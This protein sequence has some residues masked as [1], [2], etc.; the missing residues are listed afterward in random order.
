MRGAAGCSDAVHLALAGFGIIA[1]M[2]LALGL[3]IWLLRTRRLV[4]VGWGPSGYTGN[5]LPVL[6]PDI[7]Q[8]KW[9]M[10]RW[11]A[12]GDC[13]WRFICFFRACLASGKR[14][15]ISNCAVNGRRIWRYASCFFSSFSGA[16]RGAVAAILA[17][18]PKSRRAARQAGEDRRRDLV[19]SICGGPVRIT[20]LN[21]FRKN[22]RTAARPIGEVCGA[23]PGIPIISL[24]G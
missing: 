17:G 18:Q 14:G 22:P 8:R 19:V 10:A 13:G 11:P 24:S 20:S 2:M 9:A 12:F 5:F 23:I 16:N 6:G 7:L 15:V 1:A 21:R 4:D 3:F